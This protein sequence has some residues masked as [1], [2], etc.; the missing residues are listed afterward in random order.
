[1]S[2]SVTVITRNSE[3]VIGRCLESVAWADEIVVVDSGSTDRTLEICREHSAKVQQTPDWPGFGPQKNRA[4]EL[5]SGTWVLSLDSDEWIT[6]ELR[7][8]IERTIAAP[9]GMAAFMVPRSS[10]F[11]GRFM[12]HSG[13]WPDYVVRLF[14]RGAA[15]FSDDLVHERLI[16]DGMTAKLRAPILHEAGRDLHEMVAKVNNYSTAGAAMRHREGQRGSLTAAILHGL[17]AFLRTYFFR[18]GFLDGREGFMLAVINA[19]NSYYRYAK[20]MLLAEREK[21]NREWGMGNGPPPPSRPS[22]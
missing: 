21:G 5:A 15:R 11:C 7:T 4:L 18:L 2:L 6:P 20:L 10:S 22:P 16:V 19:E 8:E 1:M 3:A 14:R 13:W 17:W 12:R 9:G